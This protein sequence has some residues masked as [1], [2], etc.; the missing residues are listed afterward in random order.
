[1]QVDEIQSLEYTSNIYLYICLNSHH[2]NQ[3]LYLPNIGGAPAEV[4]L[5]IK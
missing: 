5:L 4:L 3:S 2:G 1:M